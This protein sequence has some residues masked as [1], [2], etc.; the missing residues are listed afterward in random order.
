MLNAVCGHERQNWLKHFQNIYNY[1]SFR[2]SFVWSWLSLRHNTEIKNDSEFGA[3][4]WTKQGNS[5]IFNTESNGRNWQSRRRSNFTL[6]EHGNHS[7]NATKGTSNI[8]FIFL[9]ILCQWFP[10]SVIH[11]LLLFFCWILE[12]W[13]SCPRTY[14]RIDWKILSC[15]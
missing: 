2:V 13:V 14:C 8:I 6:H 10:I 5:N 4:F 11:L 15:K 3:A 7:I 1:I 9:L 12:Y